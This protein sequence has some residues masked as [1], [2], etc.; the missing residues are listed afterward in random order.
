VKVNVLLVVCSCHHNNTGK[1]ADVF[2][3]V[4]NARI[5]TPAQI[6]FEELQEYSLIGFGSG[7]DSGK[8]ISSCLIS[9]TNYRMPPAGKHSSFR[10]LASQT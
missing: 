1:I 6:I 2:A 9:P 5:K 7:I 8:T 10:P 3:R 4:L